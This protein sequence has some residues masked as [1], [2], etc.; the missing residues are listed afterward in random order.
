MKRQPEWARISTGVVI[1]EIFG[2][3]LIGGATAAAG[4]V[5]FAVGVFSYLLLL[6]ITRLIRIGCTIVDELRELNAKGAIR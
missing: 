5:G 6:A 3:L 2:L 1:S 4:G